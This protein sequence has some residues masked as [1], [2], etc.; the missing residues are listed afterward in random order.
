LESSWCN[1]PFSKGARGIL[2]ERQ[3]IFQPK[4]IQKKEPK[5][6]TLGSFLL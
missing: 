3:K 2:T 5:A 6:D 1:S 4:K